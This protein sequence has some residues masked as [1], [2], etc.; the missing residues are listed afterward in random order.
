[1]T[2][3]NYLQILPHRAARIVTGSSFDNPGQPL[4]KLLGWKTIDDLIASE[5][6]VM[7]FKSLHELAPGYMCNLSEKPLR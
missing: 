7:V 5:S 6:N 3:I 4:I 1:M 2:K